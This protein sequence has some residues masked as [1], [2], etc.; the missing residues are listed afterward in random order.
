MNVNAHLFPQ[1]GKFSAI[2]SLSKLL[3]SLFSFCDSHNPYIC[4]L[5][6]VPLVLLTFFIS[7]HFFLHLWVISGDFSS[8][9]LILSASLKFCLNFFLVK[10]YC[11]A[12]GF[13][14][15]LKSGFHVFVYLVVSGVS[16]STWD[17][18]CIM[19]DLSLQHTDSLG[20]HGL[21]KCRLSGLCL[22]CM[23]TGVCG[24]SSYSTQA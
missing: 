9:L 15:I 1:L 17:L 7:F 3:I 16:C 2:I 6:V 4:S 22:W 14:F 19:Q 8:S 23:G 11:P 10:L 20:A 13:L 24:F 18:H 12:L 21:S 5:N